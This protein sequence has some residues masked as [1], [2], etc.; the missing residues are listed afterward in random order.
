[1]SRRVALV[2]GATRGIG[3]AVARRFAGDGYAVGINARDQEACAGV[4]RALA[5][6]GADAAALPGD[7]ASNAAVERLVAAVS[8]RWGRLDVLVTCA[9]IF[10]GA[11][12]LELDER[13]WREMLEVHLTGTFLCCRH[14]APLMLEQG[15]G[16]IVTLSSSS[17]LTGGTSGAHYAAAKGGVLAFTRALAR[18]LAP[19]GVR[20]N[21][22]IP[23]KVETDMLRPALAA[24]AEAV[25]RSVPLGR[26]GQP[27][28]VA[29]VV[30]FLASDAASYVVGAAVQVTGGY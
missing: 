24:G 27:D 13:R 8:S 5:G 3:L 16:A 11:T 10:R 25:R 30:S 29:Q 28:E 6:S 18:E 2:T 21:A 22:V 14:A 12:F 9:G 19:G 17:A 1:M 26:W 15:S 7:V 20:V 4:A 23:A